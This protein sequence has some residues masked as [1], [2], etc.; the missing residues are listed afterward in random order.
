MDKDEIKSNF[1][2]RGRESGKDEAR[3]AGSKLG[4]ASNYE[5]SKRI[6]IAADTKR[7]KA[8]S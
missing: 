6:K 7:L 2:Q 4:A 1:V 8:F 3:Q 5:D